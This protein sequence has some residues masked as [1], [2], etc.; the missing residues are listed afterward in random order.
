MTATHHSTHPVSAA[1]VRARATLAAVAQAPLW[2]MDEAEA[3]AALDEA[4]RLEAQ[5][6]E[7]RSRLLAHLD[8]E[9]VAASVAAP[10]TAAWHAA[11]ARTGLPAARR[12]LRL[13][14][15][16]EA[17]ADPGRR[18]KGRRDADL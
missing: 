6:V 13:A 3:A 5:A 15:G 16:L 18:S 1:V 7:L 2:S 8:H 9:D 4:A 10:D 17:R 12:D 11:T 14:R